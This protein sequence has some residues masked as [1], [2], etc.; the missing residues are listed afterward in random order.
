VRAVAQAVSRVAPLPYTRTRR[1][2]KARTSIGPAEVKNALTAKGKKVQLQQ[3][4]DDAS[5]CG[6]SSRSLTVATGWMSMAMEQGY[7]PSSARSHDQ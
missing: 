4:F 1:S 3:G 5:T 7:V 2:W 6:L